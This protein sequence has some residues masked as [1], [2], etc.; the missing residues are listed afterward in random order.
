MTTPDSSTK[1]ESKSER[2]LAAI[3]LID[4]VGFTALGQRNE[5]L[6]LKLVDEQ[7]KLVRPILSRYTG[8]EIKTMGDAFSL[9]SQMLLTRSDVLTTFSEQRESS[10][11]LSQRVVGFISEWAFI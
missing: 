6:S 4:M 10:T 1:A 11:S 8:K 2:R 5:S 7:R 9:S 3:M